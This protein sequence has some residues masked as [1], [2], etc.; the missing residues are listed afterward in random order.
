MAISEFNRNGD[1][2]RSGDIMTIEYDNY[3]D[4]KYIP[5]HNIGDNELFYASVHGVSDWGYC[6]MYCI[7][8]TAD[9]KYVEQQIKL[10]FDAYGTSSMMINPVMNRNFPDG[11]I[12]ETCIVDV[13][14]SGGGYGSTNVFISKGNKLYYYSRAATGDI[15]LQEYY[16]FESDIVAMD[17]Q[18]YQNRMMCVGLEKGEVYFMDITD[19][20]IGGQSEKL[21]HKVSKPIGKIKQIIFKKGNFAM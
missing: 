16:T 6:G 2:D 13:P 19:A 20:A 4:N 1:E 3:P 5:L 11:F 17:D 9:G 18:H 14:D 12:D 15:K 10:K 21:L 8:K 7:F